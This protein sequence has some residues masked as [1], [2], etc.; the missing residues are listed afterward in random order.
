MINF[1]NSQ[2]P[3]TESELG[4]IE[5]QFNFRFP[6]DFRELYLHFN[7]GRPEKSRFIDEKGPCIFHE[8]LPIKYGNPL[9]IL[10]TS[11]RRVKIDN[12]LLP[13]HLVQFG[14][15][16]GGDYFCFSS[17]ESDFGSI[18]LYHMDRRDSSRAIEYLTGSLNEFLRK[19]V[20]KPQRV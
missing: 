14:V 11:I 1:I 4:E 3:L 6:K 20:V 10:E 12:A 13:D 15:D 5:Q 2:R 19:L 17:R 16:P 7:G 9:N 18:Y 8:L